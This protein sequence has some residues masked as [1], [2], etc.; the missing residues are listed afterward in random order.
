M[1][2]I[3]P[4]ERL[5]PP[6]EQGEADTE[7]VAEMQAKGFVVW[8]SVGVVYRRISM[9]PKALADEIHSLRRENARIGRTETDG[10]AEEA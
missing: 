7:W 1:I 10:R 2:E 9:V 6:E 4:T 3:T 8:D 5:F